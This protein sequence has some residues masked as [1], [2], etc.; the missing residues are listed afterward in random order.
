[1]GCNFVSHL[2][3]IFIIHNLNICGEEYIGS[4]QIDD[5]SGLYITRTSNIL[6]TSSKSF[7]LDS[8]FVIPQII[9]FYPSS[10]IYS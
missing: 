7:V 4:D 9:F 8:I 5:D 6:S 3:D 1:M 2:T 10:N